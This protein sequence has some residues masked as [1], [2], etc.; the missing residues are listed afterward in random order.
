[1]IKA[2]LTSWM[3][4]IPRSQTLLLGSVAAIVGLMS[5]IGVWL[6][7]RL[8]DLVQL[9]MLGGF[10]KAVAPLGYWAIIL[11][12][13]LGGIA[14]SLVSQYLAGEEKLH[15]VAG[16]ME[17]VAL[18]GGRLR[19]RY[20]P[21]KAVASAISIGSGAAVGPEDPSVQIGANLGSMFGQLLRMPDDRIRTLVASG[22]AAAIAAAF[23]AP[24]AGVFFALELILGELTGNSL[25]MV[26]VASVTSAMFTQAVSGPEPAFHVPAYAFNSIWEL[27]LYLALG[28]LAG[29]ISALYVRLLYALQ[30]L[31]RKW[32]VPAWLKTAGAGLGI[33]I[34]GFFL[35][36]TLGVGYDTIGEILNKNDLT[37]WLLLALLFAKLI[38]TPL[39]LGGGFKGGVFAPSLFLGAALGGAFGVAA[40]H[41]F[42]AL[43][44][45]PS[46]FALVGM[47]AVLAGTVH[48]PLTATILLFEMTN[49]YRI[50]LPLMFSVAVSLIVSQRLEHD[51]VY[52][53][54]L[55][56]HGIHLDRGRDVEVLQEIMV[57]EA[58]QVG[59]PTLLET[60]TLVDAAES[61]AQTRHHGLPVVDGAGNLAGILTVQD[62]ERVDVAS[63]ETTTV[64][65]VCTR[66]LL[67]AY[68]DESINDALQ[69]MSQRDVGRLPVVDRNY[70]R[71]LVGV[72]RRA[73]VIHAY[74]VALTRRSTQRHQSQQIRLDAIT[75]ERVDVIDVVVESGA[76]CAGKKMIE[77][78]WP[79]ECLIATVRRGKQVFIPHGETVIMSGDILVIVADGT[80]REQTIN[81]CR[82]LE[83]A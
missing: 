43:G 29:P 71:K 21:A 26:L 50:I 25:G 23:N 1:M 53:M 56:R 72:L 4:R 52:M 18:T 69:R 38:L 30:D 10:G 66:E 15:G 74:D 73:D 19:Y 20:F 35:P 78:P 17:S 61:L 65:A 77:V 67:V 49:D 51:S 3:D 37:F 75:P 46:A 64:R 41:F 7:K 13:V 47:A 33:G 11:V 55:T 70:P 2:K 40:V 36:Q 5:G 12:P 63:R 28:L 24:I 16:I 22:V 54:G 42:P 31:F 6:F 57:S 82:R 32:H 62:I 48:A 8:I 59:S 81:L 58:M 83:N 44:I 76:A 80:A 34:V 39:S 68:P 60:A 9:I 45:N 27:P 79:R 14:V